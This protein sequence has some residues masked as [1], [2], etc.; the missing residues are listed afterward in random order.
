MISLLMNT[1]YITYL[2]LIYMVDYIVMNVDEG[3]L[4]GVGSN[5]SIAHRMPSLGQKLI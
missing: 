5:V 3:L 1:L 2:T 4:K